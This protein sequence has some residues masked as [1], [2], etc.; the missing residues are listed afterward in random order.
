MAICSWHSSPEPIG[1]A[2]ARPRLVAQMRRSAWAVMV[3]IL[4]LAA[5][6]SWLVASATGRWA[7][8]RSVGPRLDRAVE[9]A[10]RSEGTRPVEEI[11]FRGR[12]VVAG[13]R[14]VGSPEAVVA[15]SPTAAAVLEAARTGETVERDVRLDERSVRV[16]AV[17]GAPA[18]G[19]TTVLVGVAD[20][21]S[22]TVGLLAGALGVAQLVVFGVLAGVAYVVARRSTRVVETVFRQEDRLLLAVAHEVRS[23]LARLLVAI[24]EGLDGTV[25]AE[26]TLKVASADGEAM[27]ELI[28]DLVEAARVISG[29]MALP[30]EVVRLDLL[31]QRVAE[32]SSRGGIQVEVASCPVEVVGSARLLR[33]AVSN[34][35]RNAVRH[36]YAGGP[37]VVSVTVDG[38]GVT[39]EDRGPGIPAD[40]LDELRRDIPQGL[41]RARSGLGLALAGWVSEEHGGQLELEAREGGGLRARLAIPVDVDPAAGDG[42]SRP[43][44]E[45]VR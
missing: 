10:A 7:V 14:V 37:G 11:R 8:E 39:I 4:A 33:L 32:V 9:E 38:Q 40:R 41:R 25:P 27:S 21:D 44:G 5:L 16:R 3:G 18:A 31:V 15:E 42:A 22:G 12:V 30:G 20:E 23:P 24:D 35:V 6:T 26:V 19:A 45:G 43:A 34:L 13:D 29:A 2:T 17:P 1:P 36:G 28:D